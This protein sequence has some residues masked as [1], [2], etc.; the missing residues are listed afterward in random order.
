MKKQN[1]VKSIFLQLIR[2]NLLFTGAFILVIAAVVTLSLIPPQ[3][4]RIIIDSCF[5]PHNKKPLITLSMFYLIVLILIGV[6][7]FLKGG[8]LTIF[9]QKLTKQLRRKLMEKLSH[10]STTYFSKNSSGAIS[11]YFNNDVDYVNSLFADGLISMGIDCFKII[12]ILL[13]IWM[14]NVKTG[15]LVL[16][17]IPI[18]FFITRAFQKRMLAAQINNLSQLSNVNNHISETLKTIRMIKLFHKEQYMETLY[19]TELERNFTTIERVNFYDS[20]Y[21]PVIQL[22]RGVVICIIVLFSSNYCNFFGISIGM[23]AASID[24]FS[25]L[26]SPIET[27]GMELQ[28]IQKGSSGIQRINEFYREEEEPQK[29]STL[30]AERILSPLK[31]ISL[32]FHQVSFSYEER[33]I[34]KNISL[35][36]PFGTFVTFTGRT[37]V[38]KTT[39]FRLI[40][41]LLR[42]TNG[43]ILLNGWNVYNIPNSEKRQ[44]FGYVEQQFSFVQGSVSRQIS[45]GDE[46]ITSAMVEEAI[47]FVGLED[48][49]LNLKDGYDTLVSANSD[50]SQGQ[51]QLLGIARAIVTHPPILLLDEIT[52]NMDSLTEEHI[53]TIL[54]KA[55]QGRTILS[56]SH[57]LVSRIKSDVIV[58]LEHGERV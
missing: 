55:K 13:S 3:I 30:T 7:D 36:L 11:S 37:G 12:G 28:N 33:P 29:D 34:L 9:G 40:L 18:I 35:D 4:L 39:L 58:H 46:H 43:E 44:L 15:L 21:A 54:Q 26:F 19:G 53:V 47:R 1:L 25:G 49:V 51:K 45:L 52:A 41:G 20:C 57:G 22:I 23:L 32:E 56:I 6:F 10:L 2:D 24:L 38:G 48:T 8:M 50:F 14:F 17:L 27:L 31:Q 16:C 5:I 42:P